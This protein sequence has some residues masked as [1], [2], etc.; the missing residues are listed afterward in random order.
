MKTRFLA[1]IISGLILFCF[2][3][4][5]L[6]LEGEPYIHDPSTITLCNGKFYTFGTGQG[7]LISDDGWTWHSGAVRPGGGVAP[8]IIHIGDRYRLQPLHLVRHVHQA[9]SHLPAAHQ[10]R[11]Y[12]IPLSRPLLQ[13]FV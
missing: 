4:L 8:D 10:A 12:W 9:R 7:G 1:I 3:C 6:A 11:P 5:A 13:S 2:S